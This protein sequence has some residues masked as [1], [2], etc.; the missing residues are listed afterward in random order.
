MSVRYHYCNMDDYNYLSSGFNEDGSS[1]GL[2]LSEDHKNR[3]HGLLFSKNKDLFSSQEQVLICDVYFRLIFSF[4]YPNIQKSLHSDFAKQT[5]YPSILKCSKHNLK[6]PHYI[7][8]QFFD[9]P[10]AQTLYLNQNLLDISRLK[11]LQNQ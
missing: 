11:D 2:F 9:T 8:L 4:C 3:P 7:F 1:P 10:K 5:Y 6:N